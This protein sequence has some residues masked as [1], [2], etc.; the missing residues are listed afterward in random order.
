[1]VA[2]VSARTSPA[3]PQIRAEITT[4]CR[5]SRQLIKNLVNRRWPLPY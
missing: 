2:V 4:P 3:K 1:M 5:I